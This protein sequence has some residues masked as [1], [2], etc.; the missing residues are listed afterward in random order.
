M[1]QL[2]SAPIVIAADGVSSRL[3]VSMGLEK[4]D[5]RPMGIAARAYHTTP[6]HADDYIES[7]V[8]M[9]STNAAGESETLPGY[10]WIFP[11]GDGTVNIGAGLL[12]SSPQFK[13]VD[14]RGMMNQWIADMGHEWG[15]DETTS[16][17]PIK[18]AALPMAFNRTPHFHRGLL[19]VGDSAGMVNPFNGE[20][21]T[22]RWN[23]RVSPP[24]RFTCAT[25]RL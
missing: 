8:E 20:A 2:T 3:A 16:L 10:G 6:R 25:R 12:D 22:M 18:S 15:I 23:P 17:G 9:R 4:R 21:S 5:D 1:T 13:S 11:L 7:W 24:K 19:L 14:L